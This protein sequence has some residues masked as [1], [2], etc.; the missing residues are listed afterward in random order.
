MADGIYLAFKESTIVWASCLEIAYTEHQVWRRLHES[1]TARIIV[2]LW[3]VTSFG[4]K[5]SLICRL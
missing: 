4:H 3:Y 5:A 2:C 1:H